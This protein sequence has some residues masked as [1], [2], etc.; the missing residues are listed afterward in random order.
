MDAGKILVGLR[1]EDKSYWE[2]R[3]PLPPH[4]CEAIMKKVRF[5]S[6]LTSTLAFS[7]SSNPPQKES[8]PTNSTEKSAASCRTISPSVS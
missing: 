7:S 2:R 6:Y 3:T 8:S 1:A 5:A 4:D